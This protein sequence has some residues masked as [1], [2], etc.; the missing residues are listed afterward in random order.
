MQCVLRQ[1][2]QVILDLL[3]LELKK[4]RTRLDHLLK[5]WVNHQEQVTK[6]IS[7]TQRALSKSP[8]ED[9]DWKV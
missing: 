3:D 6:S 9:E 2:E 8:V 4:T 1:D 7:S 5:N